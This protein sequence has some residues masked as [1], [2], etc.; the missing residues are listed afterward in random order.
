[1]QRLY[2]QLLFP[3]TSTTWKAS[4]RHHV[5]RVALDICIYTH[6]Q[7]RT[8]MLRTLTQPET[9]IHLETCWFLLGNAF[10]ALVQRY[11]LSY[12]SAKFRWIG[13][14]FIFSFLGASFWW[15]LMTL[16]PCFHTRLCTMDSITSTGLRACDTD[17][18]KWPYLH[19]SPWADAVY[20]H[21]L[22]QHASYS[23]P[24]YST[25]IPWFNSSRVILSLYWQMWEEIQ[26]T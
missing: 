14:G 9:T 18:C 8:H 4:R 22:A 12:S 10:E 1:M 6:V 20:T 26:I 15:R 21:S 7:T 11:L 13:F 17:L 3:G 25:F 16:M 5:A 19:R 2:L 23:L 24:A